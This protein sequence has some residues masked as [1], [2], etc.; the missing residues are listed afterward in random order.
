MP[1]RPWNIPSLP[2]YSLA[3]IDQNGIANF[4]MC[5][6]VTAISLK[7]KLFAIAVYEGTKTLENLLNLNQNPNLILLSESNINLFNLLGKTTG[8]KKNKQAILT[9][10][11]EDLHDFNGIPVIHSANSV[12][13]LEVQSH[14]K[15][16]DHHLFIMKLV[17]YKHLSNASPLYTK[18]L[19]DKGLIL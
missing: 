2:V 5:S 14:S 3:T 12:M 1:K 17:S 9:R 18:H 7:P 11:H 13:N 10:K 15:Q 4:N 19:I 6:Y 8:S 16:G